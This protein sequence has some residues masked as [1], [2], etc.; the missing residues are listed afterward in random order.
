MSKVIF[1]RWLAGSMPQTKSDASNNTRTFRAGNRLVKLKVKRKDDRKIF[2]LSFIDQLNSALEKRTSELTAL[3]AT[4]PLSANLKKLI[5]NFFTEVIARNDAVERHT[6]KAPPRLSDN[7]VQLSATLQ[8]FRLGIERV[9]KEAAIDPAVSPVIDELTGDVEHFIRS[10]QL[11]R[12]IVTNVEGR[13]K[14]R[15][16]P[17][18]LVAMAFY[19]KIVLD[20]QL[21]HGQ[22]KFPKPVHIQKQ[23]LFLGHNI[24]Q[25]T[26]R[27]WKQQMKRGTF[28]YYV[29]NRKRQ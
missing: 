11:T 28:G 20:H 15:N 13:P 24:P 2:I 27:D 26:M 14:L 4:Q 3:D 7:E 12:G 29:Q 6:G 22:D 19:S 10:I 16:R 8:T 1:P 23:M 18:N 5:I 17:S 21:Q 9:G 25:R